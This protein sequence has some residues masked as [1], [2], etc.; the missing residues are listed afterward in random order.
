M[1]LAKNDANY[2]RIPEKN[3]LGTRDDERTARHVEVNSSCS[4]N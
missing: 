3:Y 1:P 4:Y 2:T